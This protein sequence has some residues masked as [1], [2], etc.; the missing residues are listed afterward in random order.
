MST[1]STAT[2]DAGE[3]KKSGH[4][5]GLYILFFT[6]M[7]ERFSYY[8]MRALLVFYMLKHLEWQPGESSNV[9]KWYTSLVYLTPLL[10]GFIADRFLGLR[11]SIIIGSI[12]MAAG[13]FMLALE[14]LPFFYGG[15][16]LLIAGNG[17]FKPN[18][19][20]MVGKMYRPNDSRRDGAFTI[21][22]MGINLG[23]LF[24]PIVCGYLREHV[25]PHAGF[26]A[27]GVGMLVGMTVFLVGQ[28][29]VIADVEAAG[30]KVDIAKGPAAVAPKVETKEEAKND[31]KTDAKVEAKATTGQDADE[32]AAMP[33]GFA[34]GVTRIFP[35]F[36]IIGAV[37]IALMQILAVVRGEAKPIS[38]LMPIAFGAVFIRM[39]ITLLTIKGRSRSKSTVIFVLFCAAVTFWMAFEQAGNALNI[40]ADQHTV[41]RVGSFAYPAEWFQSVNAVLIVILAG[42]F[43]AMWAW[44][45]RRGW[46]PST[47]L[48]MVIALGF[49]ALSFLVMVGAAASENATV[50][51]ADLAAL[52]PGIDL[53]KVD[54]GRLRYNAA[55]KKLEVNG[56]LPLF[57]VTDALAKTV[58]PAY[59]KQIKD[60]EEASSAA[61]E[62]KPLTVKIGPLPAGFTFPM[63]AEEAKKLELE[64]TDGHAKGKTM[65][66]TWTDKE[67]TVTLTA[68]LTASTRTNLVGAGAPRE[69]RQSIRQLEK[70]SQGARVSALWLLLSYLIAT[71]GE[72][73]LSPVGLSMVTKL[74]PA[75]FASLF[76][77]VWLLAS[78][79]AQYIGGSI[80]E[81]WGK[82]TP[83]DY[84][85]LF[86]VVSLVLAAVITIFV[87]PLRT[88]MHD[89]K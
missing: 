65:D 61:T 79:V 32:A 23:A 54:A 59:D 87:K 21:F 53:T 45:G 28:K 75:R 7:W 36:M 42:V 85:K 56:V 81:S 12:L 26:V 74:A 63:D 37:A 67:L 2:T 76:M 13:Q 47:P 16:A 39:A 58:D 66:L 35:W 6:E 18:I 41:L 80:G 86:V 43:S 71:V 31:E 14:P 49:I 15:L 3:T 78:S 72:L 40:W 62:K 24:A 48:K 22:Y 10:G 46:E 88:M 30:N 77:G 70:D 38:L 27:A 57:A 29:R 84:F 20:T 5:M 9:Y 64:V 33:G 69:W 11:R 25:G 17:F 89:V 55:E 4:P 50:T 1:T 60:M 82:I 51:K 52:P 19:S 44:L 68:P 73:C 34:G 8:G 83:G